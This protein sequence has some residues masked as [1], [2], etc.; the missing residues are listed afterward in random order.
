MDAQNIRLTTLSHGGG[1]GCKIAPSVLSDMLSALPQGM[2]DP[3]LLVGRES[4]DDAAVYRINDNQAI[5][6]TTDFFMPIVDD[7]FDFGRIAATNALSDVYAVGGKPFMALALVGMPLDKLPIEQMQQILAGGAAVCQ[8]I[9]VMVAG[10]HSIDAPEPIYGLVALGLVDP[11]KIKRND[12][13]RAGDVLILGKPLGVGVLSAALQKGELDDV[14]YA[15]MIT[16]TTQL[17][18]VGA[19]LA[20][21]D[22][23]HALTDVTGFGLMGHLLEVCRG[24]NLAATVTFADLPLLPTARKLAEAGYNTGAAG[25]NW[26]SYGHEV[27]EPDD[28]PAWQHNLMVDPQTSGGL[29]AACA[30]EAVPEVLDLFRSRGFEAA[31]VIG[32]MQDGQPGVSVI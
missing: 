21:L 31:T 10:G 11:A 3:D 26:G 15:E 18:M 13:A 7:A 16:A 19:D 28:L 27:S 22:A 29:L 20:E 23:V 17:N 25:R 2:V 32:S 6:A 12:R 24:S 30:P 14:G 1:C 4:G 5:V 8:S 9:N